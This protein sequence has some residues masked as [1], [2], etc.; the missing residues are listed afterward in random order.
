MS[1]WHG[2]VFSRAEAGDGFGLWDSFSLKRERARG[3]SPTLTQAPT[4][5]PRTNS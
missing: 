2:S 1:V 3:R 5:Y 4:L